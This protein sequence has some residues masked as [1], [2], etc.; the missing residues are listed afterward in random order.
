M[1]LIFKKKDKIYAEPIAECNKKQNDLPNVTKKKHSIPNPA[2]L[3]PLT[4]D[5]EEQLKEQ[6]IEK[7]QKQFIRYWGQYLWLETDGQPLKQD[8][9]NLASAIVAAYPLLAGESNENVR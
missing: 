9:Y 6:G 1:S 5:L 2:V 3:P 7:S 8:Y 4:F